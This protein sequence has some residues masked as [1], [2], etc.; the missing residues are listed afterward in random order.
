MLRSQFIDKIDFLFQVN[1]I[2]AL[3]GPRQC[4]K[5]TLAQQFAKAQSCPV[6]LFDLENPTHLALLDHPMLTLASLKGLIIID[7]IQLQPH[8]FATLRVLIDQHRDQQRYLLLGSASRDLVQHSSE[9]LAGRISYMELTP[10][11]LPETQHCERLWLRGGFPRSYLSDDD[12]KSFA[13][14]L[15][16]IK[17]FLERDIPALGIRVAP[18]ALRRFWM[19]ILAYHGNVINMSDLGRSLGL[20]NVAIR[21]YLDILSGT[22]MIR[23]LQPWFENITKRQVKTPKLYFRDTGIM[24]ALLD[25]QSREQ[26][27]LNAKLGAS[28]EGFA[29]EE[30]IR[31]YEVD[32]QHCFFWSTHSDA[33]L[34]LLIFKDGKRLGFEFK[35]SDSPKVTKSMR[36]AIETIQLDFLT[37]VTPISCDMMIEK[38]IRVCGLMELQKCKHSL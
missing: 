22:F 36:M 33:E 12:T 23:I 24:H 9:T 3:L 10:F 4:G 18:M 7:E 29:L 31:F 20:S 17:T 28:W 25:I 26:L 8:L 14:R 32:E 30:V 27:L 16:Y 21:H 13:W 38:N 15:D 37:I 5:T 34:D 19:M 11:T 2:I 35:F 6:T 1:P